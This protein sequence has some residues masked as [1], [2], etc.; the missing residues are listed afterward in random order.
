MKLKYGKEEVRLILP[1]KNILQVLNLKEQE[2]LS[3]PEEKLKYLL[4]NPI[5]SPSLKELIFQKKAQKILIIVNDITR[6]TPYKIILP[7][8]LNELDE[9]GVNK[10]D[11][12]FIIAT[13]IHRDN[14]KEELSNIFGEDLIS[15]YKFINHNADNP[16]LHYLGKLKSGNELW[17]SSLVSE[18]DFIITTGVIVPHYFAGFS[19]GR[20]SILPGICGRKTIETNHSNMV[21]PN[22]RAGN[23]KDNPV[24]E[25]MQDAAEK[26]GLDFNINVVTNEKHNIVEIVAGELLKSWLKGVEV[27]KKTYLYSIK[28]KAEV[29]IVS[30]GGYPKDINVYQAQKALDNAY[31][32]VKPG[33]TIILLAECTEGY[34]EPI[35]EQWMKEA[36]SP[37]DI[38]KRIKKKFVLGGHKA[39]GIARVVKEV[40]VI[41]ISSLP[42]NKVRK[43]FFIPMNDLSQA[44]DYVKNK[45]GKDFQAYILPS[46]NTV[47][48]QLI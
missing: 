17:V 2:V 20:K 18:T 41:L 26:V 24:H 30:T 32:A 21:D 14:S 38:I 46:G 27:C 34:G 31:Q 15:T 33:G 23:L 48:P 25:E 45:Y 47:V 10:E 39:Y 40:E 12:K 5:G 19:G 43:L 35:F 22:A 7:P 28:Q 37:E 4:K 9:V 44:I 42:D 6:P 1:D 13:G 8:L 36:E 29:V 3:N 11:I 16:D